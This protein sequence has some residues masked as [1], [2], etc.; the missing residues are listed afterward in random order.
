MRRRIRSRCHRPRTSVQSSRSCRIV[1]TARSAKGF[2][3]GERTGVLITRA[4]SEEKTSSKERMNLESRSRM[5]FVG[6]FVEPPEGANI[7][8]HP[9]Y[10]DARWHRESPYF[11]EKSVGPRVGYR[12]VPLAELFGAVIASGLRLVA[13]EEPPENHQPQSSTPGMLGEA[14]EPRSRV[15]GRTRTRQVVGWCPP[16]PSRA[17]VFVASCQAL[18]ASR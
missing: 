17:V 4:P 7:V 18:R 14:E 13:V 10:L 9:G 8:V 16:T 15:G 6:H 5:C 1:R 12:H 11:G 2:A 3:L